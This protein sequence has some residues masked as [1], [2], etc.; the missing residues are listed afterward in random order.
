[1]EGRPGVRSPGQLRLHSAL[2]QLGWTGVVDDF[3]DAA[4]LK[5]HDRWA[6]HI[7]GR[8]Q[9][10]VRSFGLFAPRALR[11]TSVAIFVILRQEKR[12]RPRPRPW[13]DS[14]KRDFGHYP[15]VDRMG[16]K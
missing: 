11:Q 7:P 16:K 8:Y 4:R 12:P 1:L 9:H 10:T 3:N 14:V 13:A 6:Q 15:L 5:H 2:E